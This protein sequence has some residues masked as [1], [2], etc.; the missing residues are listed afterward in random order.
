MLHLL[1]AMSPGPSFVVCIRTAITQGFKTSIALAIG[2]GLGAALWAAAALA[3]LALLFELVPSLFTALKVIGGAFLIWIG[4][5]LWRNA[6]TPLDMQANGLTAM[7]APRALRYGLITFAA[8]PKTAVFFG[9]I[10]VGLV[11]NDTPLGLLAL[12][13]TVIFLNET[14]WYIVV[15][16]LFSLPRPRALYIRAKTWIDRAFGTMLA[17][18]GL[19]IALG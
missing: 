16:R 7:S 19:K 13:I 17:F 9:A 8:N 11:P 2:F 5:Q 18:F 6:R 12:L 10:F 3:G 1:A 14:L 4:F 15:A